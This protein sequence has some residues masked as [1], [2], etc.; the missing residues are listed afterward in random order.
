MYDIAKRKSFENLEN[1]WLKEIKANN[2]Q[3][4][5]VYVVG[6][7]MDLNERRGVPKAEAERWAVTTK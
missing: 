4:L 1:I 7:K 2:G 6:N 5:P 3:D